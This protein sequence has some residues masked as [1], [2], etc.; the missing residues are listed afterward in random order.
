MIYR[1]K[2]ELAAVDIE[3]KSSHDNNNIEADQGHNLED[4]EDK[5]KRRNCGR[6]RRGA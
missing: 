6:A 4:I 5:G 3:G 1:R 2:I